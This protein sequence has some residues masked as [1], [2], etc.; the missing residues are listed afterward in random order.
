EGSAATV[1]TSLTD[2]R[3]YGDINGDGKDDTAALLIQIGGGSGEFVYLVGYVSG[4]VT[5]KGTNA[6]FIGD[7][8]QPK[9]ITI[10]NGVVTVN[11]LDRKADESFADEPTVNTSKQFVYTKGTLVAK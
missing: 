5:Y 11:F 7:R 10:K 9:T 4:T 6:V 2:V 1:E 3:A 8:I